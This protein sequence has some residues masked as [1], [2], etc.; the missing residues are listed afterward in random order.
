[1]ETLIGTLMQLPILAGISAGMIALSSIPVIAP[2]SFMLSIGLSAFVS[3]AM[4]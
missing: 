3:L 4:V 1:M 2:Y